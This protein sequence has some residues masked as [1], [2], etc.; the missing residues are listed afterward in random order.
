MNKWK[1]L[2]AAMILMMGLCACSDGNDV[3]ETVDGESV[4]VEDTAGETEK[5]T[6]YAP[7][8]DKV[9]NHTAV[10]LETEDTSLFVDGKNPYYDRA[11]STLVFVLDGEVKYEDEFSCDVAVSGDD[12]YFIKGTLVMDE[13]PAFA[14][15]TGH[16]GAAIKL[17]EEIAPGNYNFSVN[18][19]YYSVSFPITVE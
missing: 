19:S 12:F 10:A 4:A 13:Y 2:F 7:G 8:E 14:T 16:V 1:A 17:E 3:Q 18:F 11:N 5:E 9:I 15:E 6:K